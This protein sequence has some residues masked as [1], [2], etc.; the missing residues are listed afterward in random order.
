[1]AP[2]C[3]Q[4][5]I[6]VAMG[7]HSSTKIARAVMSQPVRNALELT[8]RDG[9]GNPMVR[10]NVHV[11][12]IAQ[13]AGGPEEDNFRLLADAGGALVDTLIAQGFEISD[14]SVVTSSSNE[15]LHQLVNYFRNRFGI[16]LCMAQVG[17]HLGHARP[18]SA[19]HNF[20]VLNQRFAKASARTKKIATL[21][22]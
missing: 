1:M 20:K 22:K 8:P 17:N 12:D 18:T 16:Q 10:H 21:T 3:L 11:D 4:P 5:G 15:V 7:C 14:K 6:S 13:E 9:G 2:L 19:K